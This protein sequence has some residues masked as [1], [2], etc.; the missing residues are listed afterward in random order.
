MKSIL[1]CLL[2]CVFPHFLGG[3]S[4]QLM[5]RPQRSEPSHPF[6][7]LHYRIELTFEGE[8]RAFQGE[9]AITFRSLSDQLEALTLHAETFKVNEVRQFEQVLAFEHKDGALIIQLGEAIHYN[10]TLTL[11][12][13]YGT[14]GFE[15]DSEAYGMGANY[16]LGLGF[17][18][19]NEDHP[20]LFN[21]YSFPNGARHWFP[22]YDHPQDRATHETIITT[23]EDHQVLANGILKSVVANGDGT[24]TYHWSQEQ[25]HPTYLYNFV[26]GV[27]SIIKDN[28]QG[29]PVNYWVYPKDED[30]AL[31]S[32]HRTP[33]VLAFFE[34]YFGVNYPWDKYDQI[35]VPGIGGGAEATTATL[36]GASTLHDEKAEKD[37]PSHW[38][39]AHEAA[40]HW[41]GNF[42]SYSD[43]T[44]T[45]ISE[46]FATYS[47]YLYS[48]H[49]Y[50]PEEGALNLYDK[51]TAYLNE[52]RNNYLRPIVFDRWAFPN[53]NF[54]R[55]TYQKGA[56]VLNMLSD[57]LGET[58]FRRVLQHFLSTHAYQAV[59][60]HDFLKSIRDVSGQN[61]DWFFDQWLYKAGHPVLEIDYTWKEQE[62][63]LELRVRQV[64]DAPG[65]PI[66][67][68]PVQ[69]AVTNDKKTEV[70]SIWLK[71]AS[72]RFTFPCE[73]QPRMV[74]FD[75]DHI[76]LKEWT[77]PKT[78]EELIFQARHDNTLGRLWAI[79]EL[80]GFILQPT[81]E[82][83]M[84][85][86]IRE[87]ENWAVRREALLNLA[88]LS[89][90][91]QL[92]C[93]QALSDQH[94]QVR[95]TAIQLLGELRNP[96][97]AQTFIQRF[98][99]DQSYL[100]R[101]AAIRALGKLEQ[102]RYRSLFEQAIRQESPRDILKR[103]GEWALKQLEANK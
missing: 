35:C 27:Y 99:G 74:R 56:L 63:E 100:V 75:P 18:E 57:Y 101:A 65:V 82:Y 4:A 42:V 19:A 40:H 39:V 2:I 58:Q 68:L 50:G 10:D 21:T 84:R 47:E 55:H 37:F 12:I 43:W 9:T 67:K 5:E 41:W 44:Q 85:E 72:Q 79:K 83:F 48:A 30:K 14:S 73:S 26:S 77:F 33:E 29:I 11:H 103:A 69:V 71:K 24:I 1:F 61:L 49:L 52:A 59:D 25:A 93:Q 62:K 31:R 3:Q 86:R 51:R 66:F 7:V 90:D 20:F 22:G 70:H 64:Q 34:E 16:P 81:V 32:F 6:D 54:D 38:L 76:L 28:Y 60:T 94:S 102:T 88:E 8:N 36:I 80:R 78:P 97:L 92:D 98:E 15:V 45:W 13:N 87:E 91:L 23:Q 46:S 17:F 53:Q 96:P 95:E 89:K